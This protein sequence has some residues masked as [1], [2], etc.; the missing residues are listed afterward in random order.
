MCQGRCGGGKRFVVAMLGPM[1]I[2]FTECLP[3][4]CEGDRAMPL[5]GGGAGA[6]GRRGGVARSAAATAVQ[7]GGGGGVARGSA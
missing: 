2:W 6:G 5:V 1:S 7:H 3:W 4:A